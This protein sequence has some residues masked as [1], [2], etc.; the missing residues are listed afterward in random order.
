MQN[1]LDIS[2][3]IPGDKPM[4]K[5]IRRSV[6]VLSIDDTQLGDKAY[7]SWA[8]AVILD[9]PKKP[10]RDWQHDLKSRMPAAIHAAARCGA[11]VFVRVANNAAAEL[12]ATVFRGLAGIVLTG[13]GGPDDICA[14]A[15]SLTVLEAARGIPSGTLEIDI[16][17]DN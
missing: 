13:V 7:A 3:P 4:P 8:D 16:E 17:V 10:D 15:Q 6:L 1:D 9:F 5:F 11:E 14:A 12:E 2:N